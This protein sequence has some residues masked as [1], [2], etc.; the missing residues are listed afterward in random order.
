[1]GGELTVYI[2][3]A[4][5]GFGQ[6]W[7]DSLWSVLV[8]REFP[9]FFSGLFDQLI[10]RP[11]VILGAHSDAKI[12]PQEFFGINNHCPRIITF[13]FSGHNR[14]RNKKN[15]QCRRDETEWPSEKEF[16]SSWQW[17]I[18]LIRHQ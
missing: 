16:G 11:I 12:F 14:F 4:R 6:A 17:G 3:K 10:I 7:C 18:P 13:G 15:K 8:E 1:L 2:L 9:A 5:P